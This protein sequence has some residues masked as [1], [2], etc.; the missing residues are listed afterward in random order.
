MSKAES[1]LTLSAILPEVSWVWKFL[2]SWFTYNIVISSIESTKCIL[3]SSCEGFFHQFVNLQGN[4]YKR[5]LKYDL[6]K[7][8]GI[9]GGMCL[10]TLLLSTQSYSNLYTG[11]TQLEIYSLIIC[12]RT[13]WI[14]LWTTVLN[15]ID[16][17][18]LQHFEVSTWQNERR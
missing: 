18:Q 10:Q 7:Q 16:K 2:F 6:W 4:L 11:F 1:S 8:I 9:A 3:A 13:T 15:L 17:Q 14:K 5:S 12:L